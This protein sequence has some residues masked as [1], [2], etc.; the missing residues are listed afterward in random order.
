MHHVASR[1]ALPTTFIKTTCKGQAWGAV[2]I[3]LQ[4]IHGGMWSKGAW[5]WLKAK[6][7]SGRTNNA[8]KEVDERVWAVQ[9][10]EHTGTK[11]TK[12]R[13]SRWKKNQA[14]EGQNHP[15]PVGPGRL[16]S[17]IKSTLGARL[18]QASSSSISLFVCSKFLVQNRLRLSHP[19]QVGFA[20]QKSHP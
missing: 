9:L 16:A 6:A 19:S 11:V 1:D 7:S 13:W 15:S 4:E 8:S 17:P 18:Q 12:W 10:V 14:R 3:V 5:T 20:Q 2:S